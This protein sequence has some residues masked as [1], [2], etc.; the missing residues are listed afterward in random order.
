M[1]GSLMIVRFTSLFALSLLATHISMGSSKGSLLLPCVQGNFEHSQACLEFGQY[2]EARAY[3]EMT[4]ITRPVRYTVQGDPSGVVAEAVSIWREVLGDEV[5]FV[6]TRPGLADVYITFHP[7]V[8]LQGHRVCGLTTFRRGVRAWGND[9]YLYNLTG[10]IELATTAPDGRL[11]DRR[12][13][14]NVALHEVGHVLGLDDSPYPGGVMADI[15]LGS[16]VTAPSW[17][18]CESLNSLR[19]RAALVLQ[20]AEVSTANLSAFSR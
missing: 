11:M 1:R 7:T 6:Q 14:L 8:T 4:L 5:T 12:T 15:D 16:P 9:H 3:A 17:E 19:S 13:A 18:E 2:A 10:S 20:Q